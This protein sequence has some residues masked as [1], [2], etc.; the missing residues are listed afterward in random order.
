M[1]FANFHSTI[2]KEKGGHIKCNK[3]QAKTLGKRSKETKRWKAEN[4]PNLTAALA[5][6]PRPP[7]SKRNLTL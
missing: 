2:I 1:L 7:F 5:M 4:L 3:L 6:L